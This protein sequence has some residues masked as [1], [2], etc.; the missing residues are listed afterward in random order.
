[1]MI[2]DFSAEPGFRLKSF[3]CLSVKYGIL[4]VTKISVP[5]KGA[6][7]NGIFFALYIR[8]ERKALWHF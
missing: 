2:H 7:F 6:L 8:A 1:M 4:E 5:L 3:F